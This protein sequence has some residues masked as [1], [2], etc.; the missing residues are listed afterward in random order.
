MCVSPD[1]ACVVWSQLDRS[2]QDLM[3]VE[4]FR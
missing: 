2:T 3:L 4:G 1:D